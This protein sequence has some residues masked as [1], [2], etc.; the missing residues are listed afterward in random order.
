MDRFLEYVCS[1]DPAFASR[2][3]GASADEIARV[4][5]AAGPL[6]PDYRR[7]LA[8]MGRRDDELA[9]MD[10]M[11]S[12][13]DIAAYYDEVASGEHEVPE[14]LIVFAISGL[15]I[16]QLSFE[17]KEPHRVFQVPRRGTTILWA[18]SLR[19]FLYKQ[20]FA[21]SVMR[22]RAHAAV[23]VGEGQ[24]PGLHLAQG[25]V[26]SLGLARQ[27]FSDEVTL[28]YES[29]EESVAIS[30]LANEKLW[31]RLSTDRSAVHL[32]LLAGRLSAAV[33]APLSKVG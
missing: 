9:G 24:R 25:F 31:A 28:C 23:Y 6:P 30:Q 8:L 18:S 20:A 1:F 2:I 4:E 17:R 11:T 10:V 14:G 13:D 7:F 15:S 12:A 27:W 22:R 21:R 26:A 16:E 32:P 3:E 5:R 33:G 29:D 19:G